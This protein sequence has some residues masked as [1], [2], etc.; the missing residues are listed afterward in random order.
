VATVYSAADAYSH[1]ADNKV[2]LV[3]LDIRMPEVNGLE[4]LKEIRK[5]HPQT[6][7]VMM[8]AYTTED[9]LRKSLEA[10]AKGFISKPFELDAFRAYV[11]KALSKK[12]H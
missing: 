12:E 1:M 10:G 2:D 3:L 7:V 11:D 6:T 4:A 9:N 8:T 5:R